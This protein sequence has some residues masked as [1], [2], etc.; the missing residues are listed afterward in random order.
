MKK[1]PHFSLS[2]FVYSGTAKK[3]KIDNT[4][5]FEH[6]D[7][8]EALIMTI[9]EPLR[10]AWG[11]GLNVTSGYR[12]RALNSAVGGVY[13]S[14]H[15]LGYAADIVPANGKLK[16]F[17]AFAEKWLHD[18]HTPFDQSIKEKD[19]KG[20]EW[21]HIALYSNNGQQRRQYLSLTK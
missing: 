4:P 12:C 7:H 19:R 5:D 8:L 21:W 18:T 10:V 6:I 11:S 15:Q 1:F 14:V 20:N 16:E 17:M 3:R 2:E 9:L 13:N